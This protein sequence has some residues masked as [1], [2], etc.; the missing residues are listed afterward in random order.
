MACIDGNGRVSVI[1]EFS[2]AED[3]NKI[4][5]EGLIWKG[6]V[7]QCERYDRKCRLRQCFRCHTY[8]HIG[9]QC[10]ATTTC[11]YCAQ[12]HA[13]RECPTRNDTT[14]PRKCAICH[15]DHKSWHNECPTR[16]RELAKIKEA[17]QRRPI[18]PL[19]QICRYRLSLLYFGLTMEF[20][21]VF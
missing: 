15:G 14:T 17:Y 6:E 12:G 19:Q 18:L 4:I 8:G 16:K 1:V 3:A 7:F 11:G 10:K 5:D 13:T 20:G 9:T 2:R 21:M